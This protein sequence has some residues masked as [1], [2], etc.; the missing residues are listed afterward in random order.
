MWFSQSA[1]VRRNLVNYLP[2]VRLGGERLP[3]RKS[4]KTQNCKERLMF[5]IRCARKKMTTNQGWLFKML[6]FRFG[7]WRR[8]LIDHCSQICGKNLL[9]P[10]F[11]LVA[12]IWFMGF[13]FNRSVRGDDWSQINGPDRNGVVS[14]TVLFRDL[15]S[16][17]LKTAWSR[18]IGQGNSGPV[19]AGDKLYIFHRPGK[20]YLLEA[21]HRNTGALLWKRE[22]S[23]G[24]TG[25]VDGDLGPKS[26]PVVY[27]GKIFLIGAEGNLFCLDAA[28]GGLKW[29]K[30]LLKDYRAQPGY[31]GVGSSPIVVNGL[32]VINVG[33]RDASVVALDVNTG[34]EV[35]RAFDDDASYSS[36]I[37]IQID[38]VRLV[39]VVTRL[40]LVGIEP[41]SGRILFKT[42]FGKSGPTVN[43]AIPLLVK[44][45][46]G[47]FIFVSAAYGVGS[48]WYQVSPNSIKI[49]WEN[50][51]SFSSQYSTP[52]EFG[53][54]LFGTVGRE[55]Y[56]NGS[57]RCI[58]PADGKV[59]WEESSFPVGHTFLV[60]SDLLVLDCQGGIHVLDA[61]RDKFDR[62][63]TG[64]LFEGDARSMPAISKGLLY[65]RSNAIAGKGVLKCVVIGKAR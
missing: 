7:L 44:N 5:G 32:L 25:G 58:D 19:V 47:S 49:G 48:K 55:D 59:L 31:F 36:P 40:N 15:N 28:N 37:E 22:L 56:G 27:Q 16:R 6:L 10:W 23:A 62:I 9:V 4:L 35:W 39:V 8:K 2:Q 46:Q 26:V 42:P 11:V 20:N 21:L 38:G 63:Y 57:Y 64:R 29:K 1:K 54:A 53:G 60:G 33:G 12:A 34:K 61:N 51:S 41:L 45:K 65:A 24:Y 14:D 52:V 17:K 50:D 18:E 30:E 13:G 3:Q 43:G